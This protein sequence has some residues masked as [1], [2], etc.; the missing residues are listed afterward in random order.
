MPFEIVFNMKP[1]FGNNKKFVELLIQDNN[2]CEIN[3]DKNDLITEPTEPIEPLTIEP[4]EPTEPLAEKLAEPS[5][6]L[7][8]SRITRSRL[9]RACVKQNQEKAATKMIEK[10][11][12]KRNKRTLEFN[13][14]DKISVRIPRIDRGGT[15][16]PR[17]PGIKRRKSNDF[18]EITTE[19]GILQDCLRECDLELY[20][21]PLNIDIDQITI[22]LRTVA[23]KINKRSQDVKD[24]EISCDCSGK[25]S[26]KRCKCYKAGLNCNSHCHLKYQSSICQNNND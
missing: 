2:E 15:D 11:N 26:N 20:H 7:P 19:H 25:C 17:L 24:I 6:I 23:N 9:L 12:K 4:S 13:V 3:I 22:A 18:Y 16:L 5:A 10:H 8:V 21:G 1:N 14:G